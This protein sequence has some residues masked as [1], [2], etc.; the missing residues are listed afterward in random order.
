M[1]I[2]LALVTAAWL[3]AGCNTVSGM[4][5]DIK[6]AG[7]KI[8]E[9]TTKKG[10]KYHKLMAKFHG[11]HAGLTLDAVDEV[12]EVL[13]K[14]GV[15]SKL[16]IVGRIY[17]DGAA[18]GAATI[19]GDG[20]AM[21]YVKGLGGERVSGPDGLAANRGDDP[22]AMVGWLLAPAA[23]AGGDS[24]MSK[25]SSDAVAALRAIVAGTGSLTLRED[26]NLMDKMI[27]TLNEEGHLTGDIEQLA[28]DAITAWAARDEKENG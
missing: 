14:V 20:K 4:G 18:V 21:V 23:P 7:E 19:A 25:E 13:D 1:K 10:R 26:L 11:H 28:Q 17:K 5:K 24:S 6:A 9:A 22:A 16:S 3:L 8:E 2:V 27:S 12:D 15:D